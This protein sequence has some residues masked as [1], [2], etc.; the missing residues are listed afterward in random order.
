M[1]SAFL[2]RQ[3]SVQELAGKLVANEPICLVDVRQPWEHET[4]RL[5]NSLLAPLGELIHHTNEI[6]PLPGALVV[7]YCHHGIRSLQG[8]ALLQ[9]AGIKNVA[10]LEGGIDAWSLEIDPKVSRY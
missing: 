7:V 9:H 3:I 8:A 10:S 6:Q 5:P 4:A 1:R 2:I